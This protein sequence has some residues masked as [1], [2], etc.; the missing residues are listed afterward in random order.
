[1]TKSR[2]EFLHKKSLILGKM[3]RGAYSAYGKDH[4]LTLELLDRYCNARRELPGTGND[5]VTPST[6]R[7]AYDAYLST[8][9]D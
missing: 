1:M 3:F 9:E 2:E 8:Q 7:G 5:G 6:R 4:P